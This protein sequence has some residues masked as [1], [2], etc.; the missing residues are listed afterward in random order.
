MSTYLKESL[1]NYEVPQEDWEGLGATFIQDL[2][3]S[4][5]AASTFNLHQLL[6]DVFPLGNQKFAEWGKQFPHLGFVSVEGNDL[7]V[8]DSDYLTGIRDPKAKGLIFPASHISG[9]GDPLKIRVQ[10]I[11]LI[12]VLADS[13]LADFIQTDDDGT[14]VVPLPF[15]RQGVYNFFE[16][17]QPFVEAQ[18]I[19]LETG[20]YKAS[21]GLRWEEQ[22]EALK[23]SDSLLKK[24]GM[25]QSDFKLLAAAAS[26]TRLNFSHN[27]YKHPEK[28]VQRLDNLPPVVR[29]NF[30]HKITE[31]SGVAIQPLSN[32]VQE[33]EK[34]V[35]QPKEAKKP[36]P[37]INKPINIGEVH[38]PAFTRRK[39]HEKSH[40]TDRIT[41]DAKIYAL[42]VALST[43]KDVDDNL[44]GMAKCLIAE[45]GSKYS[46]IQVD[47]DGI[48]VDE[49]LEM[50]DELQGTGSLF[51]GAYFDSLNP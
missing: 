39:P 24:M 37:P 21:T 32:L 2:S 44:L 10:N 35:K 48:T 43:A 38:G 27:F 33:K 3:N 5:L 36:L 50:V 7:V 13:Q 9:I 16:G 34:K 40:G 23:R 26:L 51:A 30:L 20:A 1:R 12:S 8:P 22:Q 42:A 11:G 6:P 19:I 47:I 45:N 14:V 17:M 15:L 49:L 41:P 4:G 25:Y 46:G 31:L 29:F 28:I 18:N